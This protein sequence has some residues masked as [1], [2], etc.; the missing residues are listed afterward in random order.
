M[1]EEGII[2]LI[3][4]VCTLVIPMSVAPLLFMFSPG[5]DKGEPDEVFDTD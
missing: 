2:T 3:K 1:Y 4:I 5:A